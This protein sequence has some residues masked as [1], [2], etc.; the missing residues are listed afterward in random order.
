M[1]NSGDPFADAAAAQDRD[2]DAKD[3]SLFRGFSLQKA[4]DSF[5]PGHNRRQSSF[6]QGGTSPI[7]PVTPVYSKYL[8]GG[9]KHPWQPL[10]D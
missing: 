3:A 2:L 4:K 10:A 9:P 7:S 8:G 5:R 6:S 1:I